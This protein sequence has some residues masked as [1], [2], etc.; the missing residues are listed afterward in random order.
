[1]TRESFT[2]TPLKPRMPR[3]GRRR[4]GNTQYQVTQNHAGDTE[5]DRRHD[6][7]GLGVGPKRNRQEREYHEHCDR[8]PAIERIERI[9]LLLLFTA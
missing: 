6:D 9:K 5:R 2:T 8:K 3:D 1:M 4:E 7:E